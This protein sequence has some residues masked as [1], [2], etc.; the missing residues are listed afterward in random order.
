M[1]IETNKNNYSLQLN[2][3]LKNKFWKP[4]M[5]QPCLLKQETKVLIKDNSALHFYP[6]FDSRAA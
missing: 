6:I 4:C 2:L 5:N 3:L 1:K